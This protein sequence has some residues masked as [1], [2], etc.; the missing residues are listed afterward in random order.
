M[1]G[2]AIW[3]LISFV[4]WSVVDMVIIPSQ[5]ILAGA[6]AGQ[7]FENSNTSYLISQGSQHLIS[8]LSGFVSLALLIALIIIWWKPFR[9][10]FTADAVKVIIVTFLVGS[11]LVLTTPTAKAYYDKSDYNESYF[12]LPNESAFYVPDVGANKDSQNKFGSEAYYNENKIAAKRFTVPHTKLE[13]SGLWSNYYVPAGRLIIVD[14]TPYNREWVAQSSRGT[15]TKDESFPCQSK[16]GLNI[17]VGIS[18]GA[19]VAED[20]SPRFLYHFGVNPP[21][22]DR[23]DPAVIFGSV[24]YGKSL[25]QVMDGPVRSKV[26][27]LVC[28][29]FTT[30]SFD[31]DNN[32]ASKIMAAVQTEVDNYMKNVGITLDYIGWGDTF[33]FDHQIQ[34]AINRRYVASQD[35]AIAAQLGPQVAALQG[36]ASAEAIRITANK[37]TGVLPNSVSLWWLPEGVSNFLTNLVSNKK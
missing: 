6:V 32:E 4:I 2:R 3:T 33:T 19:E 30:R 11:G 9:N 14:R 1:F 12:I 24:F 28:E 21:K 36:I 15:S 20:Q 16:E 5:T 35:A 17:T 23:S 25:T 37:W 29:Q 22:G 8:G 10:L 7:Q 34:D 26:Q 13:N 18:I 27:A 31:V